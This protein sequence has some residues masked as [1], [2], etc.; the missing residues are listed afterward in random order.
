MDSEAANTAQLDLKVCALISGHSTDA[1]AATAAKL[2]LKVQLRTRSLIEAV[3]QQ[4]CLYDATDARYR[5]TAYKNS[6]WATIAEK[7]GFEDIHK[8]QSKW[9]YLKDKFVKCKRKLRQKEATG[10]VTWP[11]YA[12]MIWLDDYRSGKEQQASTSENQEQDFSENISWVATLQ[13]VINAGSPE[14]SNS[15]EADAKT[16]PHAKVAKYE[17]EELTEV[18]SSE[19]VEPPQA[20][21]KHVQP[22][23]QHQMMETPTTVFIQQPTSHVAEESEEELFCRSISKALSRLSPRSRRIAR[24]RIEQVLFDLEFPEQSG[25][26]NSQQSHGHVSSNYRT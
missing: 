5:D 16:E 6:L 26:V 7:T 24:I 9:T 3:R 11:Y 19:H 18:R 23:T 15:C 8:A 2:D 1:D 13:Q 17:V 22:Q 25:Q 12:D 4:P 10:E 21:Q 14:R 20:V